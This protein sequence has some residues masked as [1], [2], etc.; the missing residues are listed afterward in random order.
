MVCAGFVLGVGVSVGLTA[1]AQDLRTPEVTLEGGF[2]API[3]DGRQT[4]ALVSGRN[5]KPAL[6][7]GQLIIADF[8]LETFRYDPDR[9]TELIVESPSGVF[10]LDSK[11]AASDQPI[12]IRDAEERFTVSGKGWSWNQDSGLLVVSNSVQTLL[13]RMDEPTNRPP[14]EITSDRL[15]YTIN[16]GDTHFIGHCLATQPG[17][18]R[19]HAGELSSRLG[20]QGGRP[21]AITASHSVVIE[22]LRAGAEGRATGANARY[23]MSTDGEQIELD[24]PPA[25]TWKFGGGEGSADQ[26]ILFPA[27]ESYTARGSARMRLTTGLTANRRPGPAVG[28]AER[29]PRSQAEPMEIRCD[30]IEAR[31]GEVTFI[32]PVTARQEGGIAIDAEKV[33]AQLASNAGAAATPDSLQRLAATGNVISRLPISGATMELRGQSMLYMVGEHGMIEVT[34]EPSWQVRGSSGTADRFVI[35]PEVPSFQGLGNVRVSWVAAATDVEDGP[36]DAAKPTASEAPVLIESTRMVVEFRQARF[37]G[38]AVVRREDWKLQAPD[39]TLQLATN[40]VLEGIAAR[41]GV[42]FEYFARPVQHG[43]NDSPAGVL[44]AFLRDATEPARR[45]HLR[46][47]SMDAGLVAERSG[48]NTLTATGGVEV[49]HVTLNASGDRMTYEATDGVLRL[50]ENARL[51]T[52]DGMEVIGEAHTALALDPHSGRFSVEGPV[53]RMAL[54]ARALT[55][56]VPNTDR[57]AIP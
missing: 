11:G 56:P 15:E 40:A 34:G 16:T 41:N 10:G 4:V 24:G 23:S 5:A 43:T 33:V 47:Q 36:R 50:V 17:R 19:I 48:L 20:T 25:P 54:P 46:A 8:R 32:G 35:H 31:P 52:V 14:V 39:V 45:W 3:S 18:A 27:R 21:E 30:S 49:E 42:D 6:E 2:K 7:S 57:P 9:R 29:E 22:L 55:G 13:R 12:R 37:E 53:R 38:G 26:L 51:K 1:R 28:G 44:S